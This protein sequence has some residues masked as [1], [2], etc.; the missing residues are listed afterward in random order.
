MDLYFVREKV[1]QG[2]LRDKHV[3]SHDKLA[4]VLTKATQFSRF[5]DH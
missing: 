1:A 2:V 5:S 3:L 4:D